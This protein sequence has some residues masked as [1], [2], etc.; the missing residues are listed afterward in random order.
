[1]K[2][3]IFLQ[4]LILSLFVL[5]PV[6][7]LADEKNH[8][9]IGVGAGTDLQGLAD[10]QFLITPAYSIPIN[11]RRSLRL[12]VEGDF[13]VIDDRRKTVFVGGIAPFFR[14]LPFDWNVNPFV[15]AG[16]GGNLTTDKII[17][18]QRVGGPFLFSLMTGAGIEKMIGKTPVSLSYR[19]RHLSNAGIYRH[20]QGYNS[21]YIMLSIAL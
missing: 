11:E 13:E 1:M 17:G 18:H 8:F 12:R 15:E 7:G 14:Y 4:F 5:L 19:F 16:A 10:T 9:E 2:K 3:H 21:Q 20:N 6:I